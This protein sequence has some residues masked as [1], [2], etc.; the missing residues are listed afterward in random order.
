MQKPDFSNN[1]VNLMSSIAA[2]SGVQSP[3]SPLDSL[4]FLNES[5][6]IVLMIVDGLGYNYLRKYGEGTAL[7]KNLKESITSVFPPSTGPAITSFLTGLA[8]Q[9]HSVTGWYVHLAELGLVSRILPYTNA[10]DGNVIDIP[11]SRV[12]DVN[13]LFSGINREYVM[14][15]DHQ[16][17]NSVYTKHLGGHARR[18]GYADIDSFFDILVQTISKTK[19]QSYIYCYWPTLDSISHL[20]GCESQEAKKHLIEFDEKLQIFLERIVGSDTTLLITADHGF[21]DVSLDDIVYTR[22]HPRLMECL[23]L[24][25]CGDTR[26]G[27]CYVRPSKV[28]MFEKYIDIDLDEVCEFRKSDDL[29]SDGWFGLNDPHPRL[30]DRVGDY[31][32]IFNEGYGL[33]NCFPGLEPPE[34]RGHHGGVSSDEMNVPLI[35]IDS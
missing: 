34:L 13:G 33:L 20:L 6:N 19:K 32:L 17:V 12:I 15:Y 3:Y 7:H 18:L 2:A 25:V 23:S 31:T 5:K 35:V 22:N 4:D 27:F 16:I 29:I 21:N 8:P 28:A 30:R 24:P 14:I 10:V 11:I 9:Q 1:I 26:T